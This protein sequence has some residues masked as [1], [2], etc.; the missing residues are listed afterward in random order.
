MND[1][2]R[3]DRRKPWERGDDGT[4]QIDVDESVILDLL[5]LRERAKRRKEFDEADR[6]RDTLLGDYMVHVDDRCAPC[7]LPPTWCGKG[8]RR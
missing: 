7:L 6:L 5:T 8:K 2:A 4:M 3:N 1:E